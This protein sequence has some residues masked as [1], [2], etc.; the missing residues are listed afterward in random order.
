MLADAHMFMARATSHC[1]C[2]IS[3]CL[4]L[5]RKKLVMHNHS[6]AFTKKQLFVSNLNI[7]NHI[8]LTIRFKLSL[9]G[10]IELN[11]G[12]A[13]SQDLSGV[14]M[15]VR[16][17]KNKIDL[18]QAESNQF[19]I[20]TM[21][22]TWLSHT[23]HNDNIHLAHFH[24]PVRRDRP[25]DPHGGVAIYVKDSLFC[26]PRPD[27]LVNDLEA[28]WIET[29]DWPEKYISWFVLPSAKLTSYLLEP[30]E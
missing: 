23:D 11:P 20:I 3:S 21:S 12:P 28:V 22:E 27:L 19:D 25:N 26:K 14:H 29:N 16:S 6:I 1:W 17:L 30:R 9:S 13:S 7:A 24:P 15:N 10:D 4:K 18:I 5:T 2:C 8:S